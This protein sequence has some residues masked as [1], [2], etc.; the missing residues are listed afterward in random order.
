TQAKRDCMDWSAEN[1]AGF[2]CVLVAQKIAVAERPAAN[3]SDNLESASSEQELPA[4]AEPPPAL[5]TPASVAASGVAPVDAADDIERKTPTDSNRTSQISW[6]T[7]I[8]MRWVAPLIKVCSW[9]I[10]LRFP[11]INAHGPASAVL[12]WMRPLFSTRG[13]TIAGA[14]IGLSMCFAL[15][16]RKELTAELLRIFDSQLWVGMLLLWCVLKLVHEMGHA[17][18]ARWHGVQVGKAGVMFFLFAPL[19][20]VDVTNAWRLPNRQSRASIAMAGVYVELL[21][22]SVAY[23][24][25]CWHP[26]DFASHIAAQVFFI[27]GP[28]T[29]LVNANPLLRLDG[30]Y[31][32]SDWT[33]I[34]NLREQGRKLLGGWLQSKLFGMR[35]PSC[36]LTGWRR[37]FAACHAAA[38]VVFQMVWMGGL[39][40]VVSM[41]A[42]P[43]G[44]LVAMAAVLLWVMLPSLQF[45]KKVWTYSE[46]SETFSKWSHRRRAVWTCVTFLFL[47]QFLVTLPSPLSRP[48]PVAVRF[49]DDQILRSP[50]NGFVER[51]LMRSG[52]AVMAGEV[53]LEL[54]DH[55]LVAQRDATELELDAEEIKWQRHEGLG[56]LGLAEAAKQKAESLRRSLEELNA[57]VDALRVVAQRDG[58]ILTTDLQDLKGSYVRAGEELVHIGVRQRMELL[59]SV[60]DADLDAYRS[61]LLKNEPMQVLLR[62]GEVIEV[63]PKKLQP[64][65]SRQIPHPALAATV[66]GPLPVAPAKKQSESSEPFELLAPRF[67]SIVSLSPAVS[68]RVHAGETGQMALR[69]QRSLARRFWE[70]LAD[71]AS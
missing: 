60:G 57:Q 1:I 52:D 31:V 36:Q 49:A 32:L 42:G 68:H 40:V 41:W 38:S 59:V 35:A 23:W 21:I 27:A 39:I 58:E 6:L 7:A 33:D 54:M 12:P 11:L 8:A 53:I 13:V 51:V 18:S 4:G 62:G 10:S 22:A 70:W 46:S 50:V 48:V 63:Y 43:V 26:T 56:E 14:F 28:A 3:V 34:P 17:V 25:W 65:A 69:D 16:Q 9:L 45:T 64:R 71:D 19:A 66:D 20:Y 47:A 37:G 29:L 2:I 5:T 24:V 61:T 30:Y 67:Q 15:F 55:E 44:L